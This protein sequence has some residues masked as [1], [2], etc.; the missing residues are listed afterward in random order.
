MYYD[1]KKVTNKFGDLFCLKI[2]RK[3]C[4]YFYKCYIFTP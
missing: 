2:A 4:F 1:Y 3:L